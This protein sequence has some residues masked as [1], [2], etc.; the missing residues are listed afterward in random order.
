MRTA[1]W[2]RAANGV[3]PRARGAADRLNIEHESSISRHRP[4]SDWAEPR[5]GAGTG[6]LRGSQ[7]SPSACCARMVR[8]LARFL[9]R[10]HPA[11]LLRFAMARLERPPGRAFRPRLTEVLHL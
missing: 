3:G 9:S 10:P 7:E 4:Q 1:I 11:H 5:A 2:C 6:N 8:P